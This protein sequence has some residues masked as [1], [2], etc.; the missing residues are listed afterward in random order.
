MPTEYD[1]ELLNEGIL[2]YRAREFASARSYLERALDN[3][4]DLQ[5]KAQA[6]F[7]LS[8]LAEDPI[9]KRKYLEETLAID[10]THVEAR[11]DLAILDGK[12]KLQQIVDPNNLPAPA[13]GTGDTKAGRFTCPKCGGRMVYSPDGVSL[14][15]E[16]CNRKEDLQNPTEGMEQDF[17][18]AM[19]NGLGQRKPVSMVTFQCQGCGARF[20][21]APQ[22]ITATCAYCGSVH[23]VATGE[24]RDLLEPDAIIPM[25]FDQKQATDYL[26]NWVKRFGL[27]PKNKVDLPHGLYLPVWVF[28]IIGNVPWK[29]YQIQVPDQQSGEE[30]LLRF[31]I[32]G[33]NPVRKQPTSGDYPV[34]FSNVCVTGMHKL[35]DIL[36]KMLPGYD[37]SSAPAYDPR[38]LAGWPAEI[39]EISMAD[40]SLDARKIAVDQI[41]HNIKSSLVNVQDVSY[42]ATSIMVSGFRL[43]LVPVW[44]TKLALHSQTGLVVINGLTGMVHTDLTESG[45]AGWL[46]DLFGT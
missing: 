14:V 45:L 8:K 28:D 29:G 30:A 42:S 7:Y 22:E 15:C 27:R 10:M 6:N 23:V 46:G 12:L 38:Y 39:Y 9:Q 19:A 20:I 31:A 40:A 35:N 25:A 1:N 44:V 11:R 3:A 17:I 21:L 32:T 26:V 33:A 5:T 36:V 2:R 37:F 16:S 41:R 34:Q 4:D 13:A 24:R 18:I 43:A